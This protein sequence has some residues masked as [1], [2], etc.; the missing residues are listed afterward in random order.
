[1]PILVCSIIMATR[2]CFTILVTKTSINFVNPFDKSPC[3]LFKVMNDILFHMA[4]KPGDAILEAGSGTGSTTLHLSNLGISPLIYEVMNSLIV[5]ELYLTHINDVSYI[6]C[7]MH[8]GI[9]YLSCLSGY[10]VEW[11][12]CAIFSLGQWN[13]SHHGS[14]KLAQSESQLSDVERLPE[15]TRLGLAR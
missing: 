11:V 10:L 3:F 7:C 8:T 13:N 1:M 6:R 14:S 15:V 5:L 4:V 12:L 9:V 2:G